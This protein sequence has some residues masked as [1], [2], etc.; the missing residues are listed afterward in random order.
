MSINFCMDKQT[1]AYR[2]NKVLFWYKKEQ[3]IYLTLWLK[4]TDIIPSKKKKVTKEYILK[5]SIFMRL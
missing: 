5:N 4:P 3:I 1:M 2:Y